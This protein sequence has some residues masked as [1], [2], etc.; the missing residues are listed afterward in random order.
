[1]LDADCRHA[2]RSTWEEG[3]SLLLTPDSILLYSSGSV[4]FCEGAPGALTVWWG[5]EGEE[6]GEWRGGGEGRGGS[7]GSGVVGTMYMLDAISVMYLN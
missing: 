2:D 4:L 1:M 3:P 5:E 7:V 6:K